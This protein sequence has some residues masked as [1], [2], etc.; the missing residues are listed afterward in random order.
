MSAAATPRAF[1]IRSCARFRTYPLTSLHAHNA[2]SDLSA[3]CNGCLLRCVLPAWHP[4]P[5]SQQAGRTRTTTSHVCCCCSRS[6]S[7]SKCPIEPGWRNSKQPECTASRMTLL[8]TPSP[9]ELQ[10]P[11][12]T[13]SRPLQPFCSTHCCRGCRGVQGWQMPGL[14]AM[15]ARPAGTDAAATALARSP[16]V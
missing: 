1:T 5:R 2:A 11:H 7:Q 8:A 6:A 16:P 14:P 13:P 15:V 4:P 12:C 10:P 3:A 9:I